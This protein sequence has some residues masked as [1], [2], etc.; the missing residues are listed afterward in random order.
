[1]SWND[2]IPLLVVVSSLLPGLI[3]FG[4]AEERVVL[5]TILNL[6]GAVVKLF[7]VGWM[8]WGVYQG[9]HFETRLAL[10]PD[11]DLVL[12]AGPLSLFFVALSTVLWL[13]TTV[14]AIGYLEG[15]PNR[16]R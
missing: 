11:L 1:M 8:V 4:L 14:Y 16:S 2:W 5:R 15:S 13:V 3:I 12:R 6:T 10:L 7:L 9:H